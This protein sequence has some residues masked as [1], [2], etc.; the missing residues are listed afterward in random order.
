MYKNSKNCQIGDAMQLTISSINLSL[1][2]VAKK[3]AKNRDDASSKTQ[4][5]KKFNRK[6]HKFW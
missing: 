4:G 6:Y 2:S 3:M 1:V 5:I